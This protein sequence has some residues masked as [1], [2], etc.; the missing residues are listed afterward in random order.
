MGLRLSLRVPPPVTGA[1]GR[2]GGG[3]L[4]SSPL[5]AG[6]ALRLRGRLLGDLRRALPPHQAPLAALCSGRRQLLRASPT[7]WNRRR[8]LLHFPSGSSPPLPAGCLAGRSSLTFFFFRQSITP[9]TPVPRGLS[10]SLPSLWES[11]GL[12][13][14]PRVG[15]AACEASEGEWGCCSGCGA[16]GGGRPRR[17]PRCSGPQFNPEVLPDPLTPSPALPGSSARGRAAAGGMC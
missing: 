10:P 13:P 15:Q 14:E 8:P 4:G 2:W 6:R 7:A 5:G 3:L 9:T 16:V 12:S 17:L 1:R 11:L